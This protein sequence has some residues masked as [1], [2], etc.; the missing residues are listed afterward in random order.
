V[1]QPQLRGRPVAVLSNNDGCVVAR[2]RELKALQV[3]MGIPVHQIQ[4]LIRRH[5]VALRSSNYALYGDM[6]RRV[7]SCLRQF[8]PHLEV[9]SIDE[10][11]LDLSGCAPDVVAYSRRIRQTV[12]QWTGIPVSIGIGPTKTL[13]KVASR[14]AKQ[15]ATHV[16]EAATPQ[17]RTQILAELP[18][19][20]LWGINYRWG[21]QLRAAGID[22]A[23]KLRDCDVHWLRRRFN[24]VL[25]RLALELRGIPCLELE[26]IASDKKQIV[27]SRTFGQ[28]LTRLEDLKIAVAAHAARAAEKLRQQA[29]LTQQ[30]SVFIRTNQYARQDAQHQTRW[31]S[32]L[33][34]ATDDTRILLR[35]L[36]H[37]LEK[38]YRPGFRY[39]K[40]GVLLAA[41]S[42]KSQRQQDLFETGDQDQ[43][44]RLMAAVDSINQT[45]GKGTL[46]FASQGFSNPAE[47]RRERRS[48]AYTT[49]WEE[50][51]KV[52]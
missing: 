50:L 24:V 20:D 2:S 47:M 45:L 42:E 43:A 12:Q 6:S 22:T 36:L 11:F 18:V 28:K 21:L 23:G 39:Y 52:S 46:R 17:Q 3:P 51:L 37:H 15:S 16:F 13:A 25:M 10:A 30:V 35:T 38:I 29:S 5:D 44:G 48:P 9:Y 49:R 31:Q 32:R 4:D 41:L 19:E 8:S 33:V 40:A 26:N 7:M 1:F 14:I 34:S 27:V